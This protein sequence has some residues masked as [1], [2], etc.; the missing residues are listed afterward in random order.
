MVTY[1]T[2]T[3]GSTP[4]SVY[5]DVGEADA[6]LEGAF[7]ASNWLTATTLQK[8]QALITAT[9][10]LDRQRWKGSKEDEAQDLEWPR[11]GTG[12][13]WVEDDTIPE[14]VEQA[15]IELA[16]AL[17]DG[18]TVQGDANT[19]QKIQSLKAGSV[20]LTYFRGAEGEPKRFPQIVHELLVDLLQNYNLTSLTGVA[21]G[22]DGETVTGSDFGYSDGM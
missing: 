10:L 3:I 20:A 18:S 22:T 13:S 6:Y 19:A 14:K 2:I 5:A 1:T 16:L 8:Q 12:V 11:T 15:G 21:T 7:H 4:V 17:I 9:R